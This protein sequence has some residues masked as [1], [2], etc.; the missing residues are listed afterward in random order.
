M[1]I[2]EKIKIG[3]GVIAPYPKNIIKNIPKP[4]TVFDIIRESYLIE[5]ES[6]EIMFYKRKELKK[7]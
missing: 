2:Y 1:K 5:F 7:I 3:D 4:G 6:G